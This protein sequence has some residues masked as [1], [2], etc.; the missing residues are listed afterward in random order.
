MD[1][2]LLDWLGILSWALFGLVLLGYVLLLLGWWRA[3]RPSATL[4][5][6]SFEAADLDPPIHAHAAPAVNREPD[7]RGHG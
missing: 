1:A 2:Y 4:A 5:T 3:R 7:A 6:K